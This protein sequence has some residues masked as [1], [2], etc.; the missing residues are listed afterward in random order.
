M[1]RVLDARR[2]SALA[3]AL[4]LA[5]CAGC[6]WWGIAEEPAY[7]EGLRLYLAGDY[8]A[9]ERRLRGF[10]AQGGSGAR[11][12]EARSMLGSIALRRGAAREAA[13][14]YQACLAASPN[15]QVEA[16]ARIGLARCHY[17]GG[18]YRQ[19]AEVCR[20][21]LRAEPESP[22]ADEALFVLAEALHRAGLRTEARQHY[23]ELATAFASS[24][25]AE[26]ARARLGGRP[27]LPPASP[28]GAYH[29]QVAAFVSRT[30]ASRHVEQ[31]RGR[32]YPALAADVESGGRSLHAVWVGPYATK[33][34]AQR[35]AAR[36]RGEGFSVLIKP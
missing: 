32:G 15:E 25:Y 20:E 2:A 9:A 24:P 34:E 30:R 10:V 5:A 35:V 19:G 28:S 8:S 16:T 11:A 22:R 6:R 14:H 17:E 13:G 36:L 27:G 29:V 7:E 33:A 31:L 4:V 12:A 26:K 1:T 21:Y 3:L 18:A 23:R